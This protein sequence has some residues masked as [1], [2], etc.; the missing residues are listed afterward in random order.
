MLDPAFTEKTTVARYSNSL[1]DLS[2]AERERR[3][4]VLADFAAYVE[5]DP[6]QMIA[7]VFDEQTRKY[8]KRGFYTGKAKEFAASTGDS[9]NAALWRSNVIRAFFIANGRR[10]LPEQADWMRAS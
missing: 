2:T 5:R 10:L 7:E 4:Q 1:G 8:R 6:D 3:L 9:R